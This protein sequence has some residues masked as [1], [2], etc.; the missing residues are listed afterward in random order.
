MR[1]FAWTMF[2]IYCIGIIGF[3]IEL[4]TKDFPHFE[5][6]SQNFTTWRLIRSML[7]AG[8]VGYLLFFA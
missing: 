1:V 7:F 6:I 4:V 5:E 2:V 8:W 3:W